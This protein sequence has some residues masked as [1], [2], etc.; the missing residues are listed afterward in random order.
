MPKCVRTATTKILRTVRIRT[1]PYGPVRIRSTGCQSL[2]SMVEFSVVAIQL[3]DDYQGK[4]RPMR[5]PRAEEFEE[6]EPED[7][8][9]IPLL[10]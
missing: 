4:G 7:T 9:E 2:Q 6:E 10:D 8:F 3:F 5:R 1:D